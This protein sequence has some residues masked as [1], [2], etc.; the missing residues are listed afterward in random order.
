[1]RQHATPAFA[2]LSTIVIWKDAHLIIYQLLLS[3]TQWTG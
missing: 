1:M 3:T 2:Y